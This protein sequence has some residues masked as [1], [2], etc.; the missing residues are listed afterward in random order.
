MAQ[1]TKDNAYDAVAPDDFPSML[2]V[3]RYG[4]RS[5]AFDKII[6]ATHDHF[7]DPLDKKYIDF[8]GPYDTKTQQILPDEFF[9]IFSTSLADK[10]T[11]EQHIHFANQSAR[12][13]LSSILH[14]EQGALALSAS[15][16]HI[17]RDPGAQ[18]YAAN[19]TR[20]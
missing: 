3:E 20:E 8:S 9:P 14:G 13:S 2:Q 15:L 18:E 19:Q 4:N 17:L 11:P 1:I 12:W 5:T 6:S 10:L 7:W 16:C